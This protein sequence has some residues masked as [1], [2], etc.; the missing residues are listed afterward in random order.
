MRKI[1][2]PIVFALS[3]CLAQG[4]EPVLGVKDRIAIAGAVALTS[5]RMGCIMDGANNNQDKGVTKAWCIAREV[6]VE[7]GI[8]FASGLAAKED[9][10]KALSRP[11]LY[12]KIK[13]FAEKIYDD[14][15]LR[16]TEGTDSLEELKLSHSICSISR[17]DVYTGID[18]FREEYKTHQR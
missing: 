14:C 6:D 13:Q 17:D 4:K 18:L 2:I 11:Q 3:A 8:G 5:F 1:T 7:K 15:L 9:M 12:I 16:K 10:G